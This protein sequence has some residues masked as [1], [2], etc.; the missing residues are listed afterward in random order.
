MSL[1]SL[2]ARINYDFGYIGQVERGERSGS[3]DL[4]RLCDEALGT[5]RGLQDEYRRENG[6]TRQPTLAHSDTVPSPSPRGHPG[7]M[8]GLLIPGRAAQGGEVDL[9]DSSRRGFL[10]AVAAAATSVPLLHDSL[11]GLR[12]RADTLLDT[13]SVS[14]ASVEAWEEAADYAGTL[15][16]T[17]APEEFLQRVADE[18]DSIQ[19]LLSQRQP[20]GIQKRLYRVMGQYAGLIAI[21]VSEAGWNALPWYR[22]ALRAAEEGEDNSL[23]AWSLTHRS[24]TYLYTGDFARAVQLAQEAQDRA[25]SR[26]SAAG[27]LAAA[28]EARAQARLGRRTETLAAIQRSDDAFGRLGPA[29]TRVNLL[30][31]FEHVLR[32]FQSYALTAI[33]QTDTALEVQGRALSLGQGNIVDASLLQLDMATCLLAR[34]QHDEGCHLAGETLTSFPV[35]SRIALVG[36]RAQEFMKLVPPGTAASELRG[37]LEAEGISLP[38]M[39]ASHAKCLREAFDSHAEVAAF[40]NLR[41]ESPL[42]CVPHVHG[43]AATPPRA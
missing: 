32:F 29:E 4:A 34:G 8:A 2:A 27:S 43:A 37:V 39:R 12:L 11:T 9:L 18:F 1:R 7:R 36:K 19:V 24:T 14:S 41:T 22:T 26:N 20:L 23:A 15:V 21:A 42:L 31:T 17:A 6:V 28:M 25:G 10:Q 38:S 35:K 16:L 33:G 3:E 30:G 13:Q 40:Q 5:G